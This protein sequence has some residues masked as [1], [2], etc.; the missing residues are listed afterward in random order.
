MSFKVLCL[1]GEGG[2]GGSSR[3]LFESLAHM[4]RVSFEP[5][6][7]CARQGPI[8]ARY[9]AL[10][11]PC[12]VEPLMPRFTALPRLSRNLYGLLNVALAYRAARPFLDRLA[13]AA[14]EAD[15]VHL[16]HEGLFLL[17][18]WLRRRCKT[19]I[20]MHVR[21]NL[22]DS[23][24]ARWQARIVGRC[25][26]RLVFI[27][28]NERGSFVSLGGDASRGHIILNIARAPDETATPHPAVPQ[29]GRFIVA[30]LANF[31]LVRGTD[32]LLDIAAEL[33]QRGRHDIRLVVAGDMRMRGRLPR[34]LKAAD[35]T[36]TSLD[37]LAKARGLDDVM[38]FL[39]HVAEPERVLAAAHALIRPSRGNDPWGRDVLEA[40]AAGKPVIATGGYDRFVENGTTGVLLPEYSA[41]AAA[42][43]IIRL[44]D[45]RALAAGLG[46]VGRARVLSLCDGKAR[47]ADLLAVWRD[48]ASR[49]A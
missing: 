48:A 47:A 4:D 46:A 16:N 14:A 28:E 22:V 5:A 41:G 40:L 32:R 20:V 2:F 49:A 25:A 8:A 31:A 7:W 38:V 9:R 35:P 27:T 1:D 11:V 43:A 17:A 23:P 45:D 19:P 21:T 12:V 42:D 33:K 44:A 34:D 30:A 24:I 10:G 18:R 13:K 26:D 6:V 37:Q 15:V 39:G 3:S 29:D 36:A